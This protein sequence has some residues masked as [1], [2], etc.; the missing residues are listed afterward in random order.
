[1]KSIK[2]KRAGHR[3]GH[4]HVWRTRD[5][6]T[7]FLFGNLKERGYLEDVGR[8]WKDNIKMDLKGIR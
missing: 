5:I 7:G 8:I 6:H 1:M 2:M 4:M 3:A